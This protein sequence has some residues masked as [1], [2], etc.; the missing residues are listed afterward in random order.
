M[1]AVEFF[2]KAIIYNLIVNRLNKINMTIVLYLGGDQNLVIELTCLFQKEGYHFIVA[3]KNQQS[4]EIVLSKFPEIVFL[5]EE[6]DESELD[7]VRKIKE[8]DARIRVCIIADT[9]RPAK[10]V[11]AWECGI[12]NYIPKTY[13]A[14]G[15]FAYVRHLKQKIES[16]D[17]DIHRLYA[18]GTIYLDLRQ[19]HL[20]IS[21]MYIKLA[22]NQYMI[23]KMLI[24]HKNELIAIQDILWQVWRVKHQD[25][26]VTIRKAICYFR[27]LFTKESHIEI[28]SR[29]RMG[30]I[31]YVREDQKEGE[32]DLF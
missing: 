16:T 15:L 2:S 31:L 26:A 19:H 30:Y 20:F 10:V 32:A 6:W 17:G 11:K 29:Y 28:K 14:E 12:E 23:L 25:H 24:E 1:P 8:I 7:Y 13:G 18:T 4:Y 3:E 5:Q 27:K 21:G 22:R 9:I